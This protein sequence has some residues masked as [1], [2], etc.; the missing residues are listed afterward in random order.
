MSFGAN[1]T[2]KAAEN[3]LGGVSNT[4]LN[5][6]LPMFNAAGQ[7]A[8]A[9]GGQNVASGTNFL[10]T[11]LGGNQ[12]NT[13]ALLQPNISQIQGSNANTMNAL[14]T[15]TPRGGGRSGSLFAQSLAPTGEINSLFNGA[16][17]SAATALP[18]IGL[19]QQ[20]IGANLLGMGNQ[21]LSVA[22]GANQ[23]LGQMGFQQQQLSNQMASGIASGILGL[24][25]LPFGGGSSAN[26][27][28]GLIGGG[29]GGGAYSGKGIAGWGG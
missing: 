25:T 2:S 13:Q 19:Q 7:G 22:T 12:A 6:Q 27:L 15:L 28:L 24:A 23:S 21:D 8:L 18:Q 1:N 3:N 17:T 10:N 16:R 14:N 4:A 5:Q 9:T 11:V 20:G 26:G 29:G